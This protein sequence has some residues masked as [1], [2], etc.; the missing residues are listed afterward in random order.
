[1]AAKKKEKSL[2][3]NIIEIM[4]GEAVFHIIGTAP[5]M[6]NCMSYK[7]MQ[8]L[9]M[10]VKRTR[11]ELAVQ[12]KHNPPEEYNASIYYSREDKNPTLIQ[13]LGSAFRQ[14]MRNAALDL[15]GI[16]KAEIGRL[17]WVVGDRVNIYGTPQLDMRIVR[18]AGQ[19][20]APDV[21][22]RAIQPEWAASVTVRYTMPQLTAKA[23]TNLMAAAGLSIGVGD[24]RNEKGGLS[25]GLWRIC[26]PDDEDYQRIVKTGGRKMQQISMADPGFYTE[27]SERLFTWW[28][29]AVKEHRSMKPMTAKKTKKTKGGNGVV[30]EA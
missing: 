6:H 26:D 20:R 28:V 24:G 27:E 16:T 10:P 2:E 17:L 30:A 9:L 29:E 12:L 18:Q 14:A 5:L 19:T 11:N 8:Q 7:S 1:M 13:H 15:P 3:L 4:S 25:Y 23:V 21:R 22:T